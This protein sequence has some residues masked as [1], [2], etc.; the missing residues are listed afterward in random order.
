L[1]SLGVEFQKSR[2]DLE[3]STLDFCCRTRHP[4]RAREHPQVQPWMPACAGMT[5]PLKL[6]PMGCPPICV[7]LRASDRHHSRESGGSRHSRACPR[8]SGGK[9]ESI[10]TTAVIPAKAGTFPRLPPRLPPPLSRACPRGSRGAPPR[11]RGKAGTSSSTT[12]DARLRGHDEAAQVDA[13]GMPPP[14]STG[15][16]PRAGPVLSAVEGGTEG[17]QV[18]QRP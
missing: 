10:P 16:P 13:Y 5:K 7:N 4:P 18:R 17:G 3:K 8:G 9:R 11:K 14:V 1:Q 15:H 12:L 6:T 2:V